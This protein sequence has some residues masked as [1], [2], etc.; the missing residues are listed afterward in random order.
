[1]QP[2]SVYTRV[3][4]QIET[5]AYTNGWN[6]SLAK[7]RQY[8]VDI[9]RYTDVSMSEQKLQVVITNYHHEHAIVQHLFDTNSTEHEHTWEE[10]ISQ[11]LRVLRRS[12]KG[13]WLNDP[14]MDEDDIRQ[15]VSCEL[16]RALPSYQ[17][18]SRL[19]TWAFSVAHNC[20]RQQK[21]YNK[22]SKRALQPESLDD[23]HDYELPLE[24]SDYV[25]TAI[26]AKSLLEIINTALQQL[27]DQRLAV[28]FQLW[29]V[30]D[31]RVADIGECVH[32]H[33][34]RVR[35]LLHNARTTLE[36]HPDIKAW[37]DAGNGT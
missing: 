23:L 14:A 13:V 19:M 16:F 35:V 24:I 18:Q 21:R 28:I 33:P 11:T 36:E 6:L 15:N 7:K 27:P 20:L 25:E 12:N 5:V 29:A 26:H 10:W 22:A 34:S 31:K 9:S 2:D 3:L 4:T 8:A 32:L 30:Q 17:Y 1:M 37:V